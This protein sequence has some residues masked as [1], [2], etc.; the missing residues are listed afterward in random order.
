MQ[1]TNLHKKPTANTK[2]IKDTHIYKKKGE[3]KTQTD[4]FYFHIQRD[5]FLGM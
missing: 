5:N 3:K 4:T 2:L 1:I